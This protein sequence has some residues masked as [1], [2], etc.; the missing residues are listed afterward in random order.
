MT[1]RDSRG[2][3]I[4]QFTTWSPGFSASSPRHYQPKIDQYQISISLVT[5]EVA[6][7]RESTLLR[8]M[9]IHPPTL[10]SAIDYH[11]AAKR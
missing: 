2:G 8:Y 5:G 6:R 9:Y 7:E 4:R 11:C 3:G 1:I 10:S